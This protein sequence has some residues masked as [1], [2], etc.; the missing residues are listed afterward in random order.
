M[1]SISVLEFLL[2]LLIREIFSKI[3]LKH[4]LNITN[5]LLKYFL[6]YILL[7][8]LKGVFDILRLKF[9]LYFKTKESEHLFLKLFKV[10][11]RYFTQNDPTYYVSR[12][13]SSV[14]VIFNII[15]HNIS[16][17]TIA[18]I[19][20]ILSLYF[21]FKIDIILSILL[22]III[23]LNYYGYKLLNNSLMSKSEKAQKIC[24]ENYKNM[25]SVV[26][27]IEHIK[28]CYKYNV[29]SNIVGN[30]I[31]ESEHCNNR[32]NVIA[33][34]GSLSI[35]FLLN[36][37]RNAIL[38][39]VVYMYYKNKIRFSDILFIELI[40]NIF[41]SYL[42]EFTSLNL[43][44]RDVKVAL[45]FIKTEILDKEETNLGNKAL[46]NIDIIEFNIDKFAYN[47]KTIL[48]DI[49]FKIRKGERI[50]IVGKSG[51]GKSTLVKLL[52]RFF[53]V[54]SI[55]INNVNIKD[56]N[57]KSLRNKFYMISQRVA[58]FPGTI[59][60]NITY[61]LETYDEKLL[62]TILDKNFLKY[63]GVFEHGIDTVIKENG[64]NLSG[65][66]KQRIAIARMIMYN[67][68]VIV[69]DESTSSLDYCSE[70]EVFEEI[71]EYLNDKIVIIVTHRIN[72]ITQCDNIFMI[73]NGKILDNGSYEELLKT[74]TSFKEHF[75]KKDTA[76]A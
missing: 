75:N 20:M 57:L 26:Q 48:N 72:V 60:E 22:F 76:N 62:K 74:S 58:L 21:M 4:T 43:G 16:R 14:N 6:I 18:I 29:F 42:S 40:M 15:G 55:N 68:D 46:T 70:N 64:S 32:L 19:V 45:N 49:T 73:E 27:N 38:L 13:K 41:S 61:G 9:S 1:A 44:L 71:E 25:V 65:G 50:G 52:M 47:S 59:R 31:N 12:I 3:E 56:Y 66:E 51:C 7:Y 30:Y 8:V 63:F 69:F 11:Y 28:Q 37:M 2:P 39:V 17:A 23:P 10:E 67:P 34:L 24:A 5:F 36:I 33:H 53:D 54:N 35:T